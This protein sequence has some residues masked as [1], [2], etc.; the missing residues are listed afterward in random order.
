MK[1]IYFLFL[2]MVTASAV[3][4]QTVNSSGTIGSS[5][6]I[7]IG[8]ANFHA[9]EAIYHDNEIGNNNF[10]TAGTAIEEISFFIQSQT[11]LPFSVN[12]YKVYLKNIPVATTTFTSGAY[13]LT[14]YTLVFSGVVSVDV[15]NGTVDVPL[16]APFVRT[17]GTNLQILITREDNLV[18]NNTF[19]FSS[20]VS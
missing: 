10:I 9:L 4:S 7:V 3:F 12:N 14:G 11:G 8:G 2:C 6:S 18:P 20:W 13:S 5:S 1:K 15:N 17:A 16:S 19:F